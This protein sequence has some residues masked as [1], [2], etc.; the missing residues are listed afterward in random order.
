M[1]V[2]TLTVGL[3]SESKRGAKGKERVFEEVDHLCITDIA[4]PDG[5]TFPRIRRRCRCSRQRPAAL[6][7][8]RSLHSSCLSL[9][10]L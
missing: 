3:R 4:L 5:F 7:Q 8:R 10:W 2:R 6:E 9:H 1:C